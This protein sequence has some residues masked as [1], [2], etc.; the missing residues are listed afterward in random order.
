MDP[1]LEKKKELT[2]ER[3]SM[4]EV[5]CRGDATT[6]HPDV[7]IH[8]CEEHFRLDELHT[9]TSGYEFIRTGET[10]LVVT[11]KDLCE[12]MVADA[13]TCAAAHYANVSYEIRPES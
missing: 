1:V 9:A 2:T 3:P 13:E 12:T 4:F 5:V 8:I 11:T 6:T 10:V 7:F